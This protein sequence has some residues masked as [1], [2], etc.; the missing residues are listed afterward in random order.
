MA[1]ERLFER[2]QRLGR[3]TGYGLL[4]IERHVRI[5][6]DDHACG[7]EGREQE[8]AGEEAERAEET[9]SS[10]ALLSRCVYPRVL[11]DVYYMCVQP[12][13]NYTQKLGQKRGNRWFG[14]RI[15]LHRLET[16]LML[17]PVD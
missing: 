3:A 9:I 17:A 8:P 5:F 1:E 4:A 7:T 14:P 2:P 16:I 11:P 15:R 10:I 13:E 6:Q 12:R